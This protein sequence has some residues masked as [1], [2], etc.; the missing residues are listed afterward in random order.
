MVSIF[1]SLFP[2]FLRKQTTFQEKA[3]CATHGWR[4]IAFT[5]KRN[6]GMIKVRT[7]DDM[8]IIDY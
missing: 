7:K 8:N 1:C 5:L 3:F 2:H 6:V 4:I